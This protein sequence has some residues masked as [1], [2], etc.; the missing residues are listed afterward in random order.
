MFKKLYV[1]RYIDHKHQV[2]KGKRKTINIYHQRLTNSKS[3]YKGLMDW[4]N[5][6]KDVDRCTADRSK[7]Q[8]EVVECEQ[9]G[10]K[11]IFYTEKS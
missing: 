8:L 3:L 10:E 2:G 6:G 9:S 11:D 4:E 7:S 5:N 1:D